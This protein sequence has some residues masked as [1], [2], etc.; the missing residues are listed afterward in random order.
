MN[1]NCKYLFIYGTLLV[2][3][4]EFGAYLRANS[5]PFAKGN[6]AGLLYDLGEYPGAIHQPQTNSRVYGIIVK[7]NNDPVVLKT[8]DAYEGFG[9]DEEQPNLFIRKMLAINT[10]QGIVDC[11]IYLYNLPLDGFP[12]IPSGKYQP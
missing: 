1:S 8:I 2:A 3:G 5:T 11:W 12:L 9:E 10:G 4:N 6:F 7:L